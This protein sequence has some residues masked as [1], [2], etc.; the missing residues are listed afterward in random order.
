MT[1]VHC[2]CSHTANHIF[3]CPFQYQWVYSSTDCASNL[4]KSCSLWVCDWQ[5][6]SKW[7]TPR[8]KV[9]RT[10][11]SHNSCW[12]KETTKKPLKYVKIHYTCDHLLW[13]LRGVYMLGFW[14]MCE[15]SSFSTLQPLS[16]GSL[17]HWTLASY[18]GPCAFPITADWFKL[19]Q[20]PSFE[21]VRYFKT[22]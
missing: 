9:I 14:K 6:Q 21:G 8:A 12:N 17:L 2:S 1:S 22:L 3:F 19:G 20:K 10:C 16:L 11:I 7:L 4:V 5:G 15:T 13:L 18:I